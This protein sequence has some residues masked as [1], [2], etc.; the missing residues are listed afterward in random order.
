MKIVS[1]IEATKIQQIGVGQGL[2]SEVF[3]CYDPQLG[4]EIVIKEIP[5]SNFSSPDEY[6]MEAQQLYANKHPRVVPIHY[7]CKDADK[8]RIAMPY[9]ANGSVQDKINNGPLTTRQ[10]ILWAQQFLTGLHYVHSNGFIHF[11]IKP[12]NIL[13]HDDGSAML[14]D[15]GQ[16][17]PTNQFGVG[18][19]PPMYPWHLTPEFFKYTMATKQSDIYQVGLTLYRMCNGDELFDIQKPQ[20]IQELSQLILSGSFPN[21]NKFL[22]H[23][24]NRLRRVIRKALQVD[25][26]KRQ[27]TAMEIMNELGQVN[28]LLDWEYLRQGENC[29]WKCKND[30]HEYHIQMKKNDSGKWNIE[31]F[32]IRL[33]NGHKRIK[34]EWCDGP[35]NT[36]L[37][38]EKAVS[39]IFRQME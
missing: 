26:A 14:S 28:S 15:F 2:N 34:R 18:E 13:L 7:A 11:D 6:F 33:D 22:P 27:Q 5:I 10:I 35:F 24:P 8:I 20:N 12:S 21:R 4:G 3:L 32:S 23:V 1:I 31:G 19:I 39:R 38:A 36:F 16:S 37:L 29:Y 9:F 25:P 17:R 30:T